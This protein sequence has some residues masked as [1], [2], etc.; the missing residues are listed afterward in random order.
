MLFPERLLNAVLFAMA[1]EPSSMAQK[2]VKR[3]T[4]VAMFLSPPRRL[5]NETSIGSR[6]ARWNKDLLQPS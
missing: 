2:S 1:L 4:G 5:G 3:A 6:T